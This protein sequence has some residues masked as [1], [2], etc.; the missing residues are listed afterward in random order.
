[1][2]KNVFGTDQIVV[3]KLIRHLICLFFTFLVSLPDQFVHP[4]QHS[5]R[6]IVLLRII[7][8]EIKTEFLIDELR[9]ERRMYPTKD[10]II[11]QER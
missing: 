11:G 3:I 2:Q 6:M 1:M 4:V 7:I 8:D 10:S 5:G 9:R